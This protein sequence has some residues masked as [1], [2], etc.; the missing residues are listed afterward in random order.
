MK[1]SYYKFISIAQLN[2][3]IM[4]LIFPGLVFSGK[5]VPFEPFGMDDQFDRGTGWGADGY[6]DSAVIATIKKMADAGIQWYRGGVS[7]LFLEST[8][9]VNST[10]L[11]NREDLIYSTLQSYNIKE[12]FQL[13]S[14]PQWAS[15]EPD[16]SDYYYY[17]PKNLSDF[18]SYVSFVGR[19][20]QGKITY[21]EFGNEEDWASWMGTLAQYTECL[22]IFHDTLK[23]IDPNNKIILGGLAGD[24]DTIWWAPN[25]PR[26]KNHALQ[27]LYEA[28]AKNYFNIMNLHGYPPTDIIKNITTCYSRM[29]HY[30]DSLKPLWITEIGQSTG[31]NDSLALIKQARWLDSVYTVIIN[32][33]KVEKLFWYDFRCKSGEGASENNFG[34]LNNDLTARPAYDTL[35]AIHNRSAVPI[36]SRVTGSK[37]FSCNIK[38]KT[39]N[40]VLQK[41]GFV[42]IKYYDLQGRIL[43]SYVNKYQIA[44][45]HTLL[46]PALA[47]P[48]KVY[49]SE[50]RAGDSMMYSAGLSLF[51]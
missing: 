30:G 50:F 8:Q 13:G 34:I 27:Q 11:L 16:S 28:G 1:K 17:P 32:H 9:G 19:R 4:L 24:G 47:L 21:W 5:A 36:L 22:K 3:G 51:K 45:E 42:S 39:I 14:V 43:C 31:G 35:V 23:V 20:Y 18:A 48:R 44:G 41:S 12:Y 33:P 7:W 15:S 46:L 29:A 49:I 6:T 2:V 38:G 10:S 40:Y 37:S 25:D 26:S